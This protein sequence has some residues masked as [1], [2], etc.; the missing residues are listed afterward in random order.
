MLATSAPRALDVT[1]LRM[2]LRVASNPPLGELQALLE[3]LLRGSRELPADAGAV[4]QSVVAVSR[5]PVVETETCKHWTS[6]VPRSRT[7][8]QLNK[9]F[10]AVSSRVNGPTLKYS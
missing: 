8:V 10:A 6:A 9:A 5:Q 1:V 7:S 4:L 2:T 3:V